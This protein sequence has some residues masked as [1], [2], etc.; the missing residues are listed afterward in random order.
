MSIPLSLGLSVYS[1]IPDEEEIEFLKVNRKDSCDVC[2][3]PNHGLEYFPL[4][5]DGAWYNACALCHYTQNLD[6][7]PSL[8]KGHIVFLPTLTQQE[9]SVFLRIYWS[10]EFIVSRTKVSIE[11]KELKNSLSVIQ[12]LIEQRHKKAGTY[13]GKG[14]QYVEATI[15]FLNLLP[16]DR[17]KLRD[18]LY[19][20]L[21]WVPDKDAFQTEISWW[22][23]EVFNIVEAGAIRN[24]IDAFINRLDAKE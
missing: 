16:P 18:R 13:Y 1:K 15:G 10:V 22:S 8:S 6:R 20:D 24:N 12:K 11:E 14:I 7:I 2:G 5:D 3:T 17:Y 21:R 19:G 9:L 4:C 23:S